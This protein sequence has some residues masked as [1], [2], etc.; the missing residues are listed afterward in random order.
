MIHTV[1]VFSGLEEASAFAAEFTAGLARQAV[2]ERGRFTLALSGGTTPRR[3]FE[4]LAILGNNDG[5]DWNAWQVF[6]ADERYVPLDD[7]LS[8]HLLVRE[9]F[10]S[11]ARIPEQ[12]VHPVPVNLPSLDEAAEQY[13]RELRRVLGEDG[14]FPRFDLIH[15]GMGSDGHTA[16]LFPDDPALAENFRWTA[17]VPRPGLKPRVPRVTL[18]LPVLCAA[19]QAMFLVSG[20]Y[21]CALAERIATGRET[22]ALPAAMVKPEGGVVWVA[23]R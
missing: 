14:A 9:A 22:A 2:R 3:Y 21:K 17:V 5:I 4:R 15:L 23:A 18:T 6:F 11:R 20:E 13:E 12:N 8:N 16:S 1:R 19:R 10:L 7:P